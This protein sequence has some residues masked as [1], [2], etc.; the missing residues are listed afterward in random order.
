MTLRNPKRWI[1]RGLADEGLLELEQERAAEKEAREK[2]T[3]GDVK[4]EE[5]QDNLQ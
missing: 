3:A 5:P 2:E 1:L 4:E